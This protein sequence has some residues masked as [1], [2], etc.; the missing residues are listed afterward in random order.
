M[1]PKSKICKEC[2]IEKSLDDYYFSRNIP[3]SLCKVCFNKKS[4]ENYYNKHEQYKQKAKINRANKPQEYKYQ[5]YSPEYYVKNK[6]AHKIRQRRYEEKYPEKIKARS[7]A[8]KQLNKEKIRVKK[9]ERLRTDVNFK[10]RKSI[11]NRLQLALKHN[12]TTGLAFLNLGC[13]LGEL[14]LHLEKQFKPG[15]S[16][17]NWKFDGWHLDHIIPLCKFDLTNDEQVK[18]ATH[19]TNLQPLWAKDNLSKNKK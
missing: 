8:Y 4:L 2:N 13:S 17:E 14:K 15:M 1:N 11:R 3:R 7:R 16:W 12:Y 10:L 9:N 5:P 19:Y 18:I 6:E